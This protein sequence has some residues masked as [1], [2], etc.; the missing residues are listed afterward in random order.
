MYVVPPEDPLFT[1]S[2]RRFHTDV[3]NSDTETTVLQQH[4]VNRIKASD[5]PPSADI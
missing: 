1:D 3:H 2:D 4:E 5:V